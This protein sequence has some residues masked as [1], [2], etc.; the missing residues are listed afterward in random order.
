MNRPYTS[1][2]EINHDLRILKLQ[3]EI[4]KEELKL[5]LQQT[6]NSLYPTN[7]LGG[8]GGVAQKILLTLLAKKL[9]KRF[10]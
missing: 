4:D 10:F 7:L 2:E 3:R 1:F 6:K 5:N 9:A 8:F